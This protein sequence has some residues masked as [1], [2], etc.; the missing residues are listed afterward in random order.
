MK[1]NLK[2]GKLENRKSSMKEKTEH[3]EKV[4]DSAFL[5]ILESI[6]PKGNESTRDL[7]E[8]W[9][10]LPEIEKALIDKPT[11]ENI[12]TYKSHIQNI[13]HKIMD[14]N[15]KLETA[16]RRNR[17]DQKI[18]VTAKIIDEKLH[19]LAQ[20]IISGSNTAFDILKRTQDIRGLLMDIRD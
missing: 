11:A 17:S 10:T 19:L 16:Q 2:T 6:I 13:L 5:D 12:Q 7:N 3:T 4:G 20:T 8:L 15:T 9:T 18:L 14:K 1:I